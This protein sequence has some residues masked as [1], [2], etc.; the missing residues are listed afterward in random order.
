MYIHSTHKYVPHD[1]IL[2]CVEDKGNKV[3]GP[4]NNASSLSQL[5]MLITH[6]NSNPT[7]YNSPELL[8]CL[9]IIHMY[10]D[11]AGELQRGLLWQTVQTTLLATPKTQKDRLPKEICSAILYCTHALSFQA[12]SIF[13]NGEV[14]LHHTGFLSLQFLIFFKAIDLQYQNLGF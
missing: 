12:T 10:V 5:A 13:S 3:S 7:L 4:F 8:S 2:K 14:N 11:G 1:I 9:N 6:I